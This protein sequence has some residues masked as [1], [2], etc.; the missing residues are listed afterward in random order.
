LTRHDARVPRRDC[1]DSPWASCRPR[2]GL[3]LLARPG[4]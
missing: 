3:A 1:L 2:R 4:D